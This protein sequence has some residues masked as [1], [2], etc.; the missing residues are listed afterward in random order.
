MG[1]DGD[2]ATLARRTTDRDPGVA[3]DRRQPW[4]TIGLVTYLV[5][6]FLMLSMGGAILAAPVTI[7]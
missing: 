5:A 3:T 7:H 1:D 6:G 4:G 2:R